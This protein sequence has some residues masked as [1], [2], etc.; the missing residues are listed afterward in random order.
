M[1]SCGSSGSWAS[2][3]GRDSRAVSL[4]VLSQWVRRRFGGLGDSV[5]EQLLPGV[6]D[7]RRPGSRV[8]T[9]VGGEQA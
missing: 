7:G 9:E 3:V 1:S 8:R 2:L 6:D 4:A 5:P